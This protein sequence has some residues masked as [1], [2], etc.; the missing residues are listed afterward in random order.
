[1]SDHAPPPSA[2]PGPDPAP[3]ETAEMAPAPSVAVAAPPTSAIASLLA[4]LAGLAMIAGGGARIALDWPPARDML[5][6]VG[7]GPD[8]APDLWAAV[9]SS[10]LW[11]ASSLIVFGLVC[12]VC[13]GPLSRGERVARRTVALIGWTLVFFGLAG[14]VSG[15]PSPRGPALVGVGATLILA[16]ASGRRVVRRAARSP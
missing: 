15:L 12:L 1:M 4:R 14:T 2:R 16:A 10:W 9:H 3:S 5:I 11:D 13:S 6:D 8:A 7:A